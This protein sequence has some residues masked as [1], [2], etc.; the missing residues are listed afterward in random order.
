MYMQPLSS[1]EIVPR[2]ITRGPFPGDW[3]REIGAGRLLPK[4]VGFLSH[5]PGIY[6]TRT[7][8]SLPDELSHS[9]AC[10]E[11][12]TILGDPPRLLLKRVG[13]LS[14]RPPGSTS[15]EHSLPSQMN[16]PTL[17]PT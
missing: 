11:S 8:S 12:I 7:F 2:E 14:H 5:R 17:P 10:L 13:F 6:L 1:P 4:R 15:H 16:S 9:A 3:G